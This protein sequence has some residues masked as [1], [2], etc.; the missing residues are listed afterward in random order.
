MITWRSTCSVTLTLPSSRLMNRSCLSSLTDLPIR[1][2]RG[3]VTSRDLKAAIKRIMVGS[4]SPLACLIPNKC[5]SNSRSKSRSSFRIGKVKEILKSH[6]IWP[7]AINRMIA[8]LKITF[9]SN[10]EPSISLAH[11]LTCPLPHMTGITWLVQVVLRKM[12]T[13]M[14]G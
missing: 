11:S 2:C 5:E 12:V 1:L 13:E 3:A 9:L 4:R 6:R 8:S 10:R 14:N 7:R